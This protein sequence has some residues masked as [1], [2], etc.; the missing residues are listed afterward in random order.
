MRTFKFLR[1]G[2][3]WYVDL[4]EYIEQ[5]GSVG[6]LQMVEGA[7]KMLDM[8]AEK[9]NFVLLS[10]SKEPFNGADLLVLT[11]KCDPYIGGGY[12]FMKQ[13]QGQEVNRTMW[14]CQVIEFALGDI[15]QQIFVRTEPIEKS[16]S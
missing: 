6:D 8:M 3:E 15:P 10:I 12:Y 14:L 11:E 9:E 2:N 5:G 1:T 7:D 16:I 13:Y 4:P